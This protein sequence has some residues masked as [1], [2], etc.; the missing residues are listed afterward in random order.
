MSY[1]SPPLLDS[2]RLIKILLLTAS[3]TAPGTVSEAPAHCD[4]KEHEGEAGHSDVEPRATFSKAKIPTTP[5]EVASVINLTQGGGGR[6]RELEVC[7][8]NLPP[9]H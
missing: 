2:N 1:Q 8:S 4:D 7:L 5:I 9:P 6:G 3:V